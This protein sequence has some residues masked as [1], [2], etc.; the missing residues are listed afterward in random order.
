MATKQKFDQ[1]MEEPLT[2]PT[3]TPMPMPE[4]GWPADQYTGIAG[5]YV[6]DPLTGVR[7]PAAEPIL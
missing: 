5:Q 1:G 2:T 6:R 3:P 7:R 4:G